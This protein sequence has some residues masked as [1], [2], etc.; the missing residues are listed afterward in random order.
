MTNVSKAHIVRVARDHPDL[1]R[2]WSEQRESAHADPYDLVSDP[3]GVWGW[4]APTL[5]FVSAN[6]VALKNATTQRGFWDAIQA[7]IDQF[8][9]Y[10]EEQG[11]WRLLWND[12]GTEKKEEAAQ[13]LFYGIARPYCRSNNIVVDREVE[14]GRG[15]VDFKFSSGYQH[16]A[17]LEVKKLTSGSFWNGLYDQLPAYM[18]SD[19]CDDGWLLAVQ[20]RDS[21]VTAERIKDLPG[22]VRRTAK[23]KKLQLRYSVVDAR[24]KKS[25]SKIR[26]KRRRPKG[27]R[28]K[29]KP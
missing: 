10:V 6:P 16:R 17:L 25:A 5:A 9:H 19:Q 23:D 29:R 28:P 12:D 3:K 22:E 21:G 26:T 27:P 7:I 14:L 8:R 1:V 4:N 11:G 20:L 18:K 24:N 15:P 13:L 2:E